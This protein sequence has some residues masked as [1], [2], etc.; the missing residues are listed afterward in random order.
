MKLR[1]MLPIAAVAAASVI[2]VSCAHPHYGYP[3]AGMGPGMMGPGMMGPGMMGPGMMGWGYGAGE[4]SVDDVRKNMERWLAM[5][6][7]PR[8]AIGDVVQRDDASIEVTI[9]TVKEKAVVQRF[10]VDRRSG[11]SRPLAD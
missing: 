7:N 6:G 2:G 4:L 3:G 11:F 1:N 8:L 9:V 5:R 10:L